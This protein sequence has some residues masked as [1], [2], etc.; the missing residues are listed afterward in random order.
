MK[1]CA[2]I[3]SGFLRDEANLVNLKTFLTK[4]AKEY[5]IDFFVYTYDVIGLKT[6][7]SKKDFTTKKIDKETFKPITDSE[8]EV[9]FKLEPFDK[10]QSFVND[11]IKSNDLVNTVKCKA[12]SQGVE[13]S[14]V[15]TSIDWE[16]NKMLSQFYM[17][18]LNI[19]EIKNSGKKYDIIIKSRLDLN[20]P[21]LPKIPAKVEEGGFY[22]KSWKW[23]SKKENNY[24]TRTKEDSFPF[25]Y[26]HY[27]VLNYND[28]PSLERAYSLESLRDR[29]KDGR[30]VKG[31]Q[32]SCE[33]NQ[34]VALFMEGGIKN[35]NAYNCQV[36]INRDSKW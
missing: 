2:V 6:K 20:H 27:F 21:L 19:Q 33:L 23:I 32:L 34:S 36:N 29:Y 22:G 30:W 24:N 9:L 18:W 3:L 10:I 8:A 13:T 5:S 31:H 15:P 1:R 14:R 12:V 25:I 35:F 28:M 16:L 4:N 7:A 17:N 11:F 26:D